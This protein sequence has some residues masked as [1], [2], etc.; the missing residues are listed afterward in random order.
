MTA[1]TNGKMALNATA[2]I[3]DAVLPLKETAMMERRMEEL[4][5]RESVGLNGSNNSRSISRLEQ[6]Q[7]LQNCASVDSS[8]TMTPVQRVWREGRGE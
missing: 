4:A 6:H 1:A 3:K 2:L 7:Q 8:A 5:T